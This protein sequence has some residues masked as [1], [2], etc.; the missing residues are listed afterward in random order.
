MC[1]LINLRHVEADDMVIEQ[2][3]SIGRLTN[4]QELPAFSVREDD[5]HKLTELSSLAQLHGRLCI[6][7]LENATNC[8]FML[9]FPLAQLVGL[10]YLYIRNC[11][12]LRSIEGLRF[13]KS[14]ERLSIIGCPKLL[15]LDEG[16]EQV[17]S[18]TLLHEL[19]IHNTV[20][21]KMVPLKA[22]F[23]LSNV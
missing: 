21:L 14:L 15:Q 7:N 18:L 13:L 5:R 4:L 9:N 22:P 17:G 6:K 11:G 1:K 3:N 12:E 16:D 10:E 23:R 2:I 20:L 19:W 8:P